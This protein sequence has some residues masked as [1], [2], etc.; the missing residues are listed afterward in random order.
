VN[1]PVLGCN[2]EAMDDDDLV[3]RIAAGDDAATVR[4]ARES[5]GD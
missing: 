2:R 5:A 1:R 4:G 3:A